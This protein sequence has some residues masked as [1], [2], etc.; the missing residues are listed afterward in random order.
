MSV[1]YKDYYEIL[2][3]ERN[4]SDA[5]I[6]KA[7][8]KL[9]RQYHP[10]IN[11]EAGAQERFQEISEA[12]EV[13]GDEEKR[14]R[15]DQLGA[16]WKQGQDFT[17]P[18][19]WEN[20]H[21]DFASGGGHGFGFSGHGEFSDFFESI[22]GD[23]MGGTRS[24]FQSMNGFSQP[25]RQSA[26]EEVELRLSLE[27]AWRGGKKAIKVFSGQSGRSKSYNLNIPARARDG[28][29]LRLARQGSN[30]TDLLVCIRVVPNTNFR[31]NGS[32]IE[33]DLFVTPAQAALGDSV[34][35]QLPAGKAKLKLHPGTPSGKRLKMPGK[36]MKKQGGGLGDVYVII[37]IKIPDHLS[38]EQRILYEQLRKL[39]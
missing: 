6:K 18:P 30:G 13:L 5:A 11:K 34:E 22:F 15:Y 2:N 28:L 7:Y 27:E 31:L 3:V 1:Q 17:P 8:R 16:N 38:D 33:T 37:K 19:G 12:Y 29:K 26:A 9:A 23:M 24:G 32:D 21:F 35:L 36:G 39:D 14:K 4:S 20:I 10:D 25:P